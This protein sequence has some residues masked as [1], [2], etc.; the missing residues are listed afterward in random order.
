[1]R[2]VGHA[3]GNERHRVSA[4]DVGSVMVDLVVDDVSDAY[5]SA[6]EVREQGAL[7]SKSRCPSSRSTRTT[8][9]LTEDCEM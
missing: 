9:L 5:A 6:L 8:A 4:E 1:M 7:R 3:L 2:V